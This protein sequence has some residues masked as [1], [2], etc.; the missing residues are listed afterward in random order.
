MYLCSNFLCFFKGVIK[1]VF[2]GKLVTRCKFGKI[3][4]G[5]FYLSKFTIKEHNQKVMGFLWK[6]IKFIYPFRSML[7]HKFIG[8]LFINMVVNCFHV[9]IIQQHIRIVKGVLYG[10]V[11]TIVSGGRMEVTGMMRTF[12][13]IFQAIY[14]Q[15]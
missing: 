1:V 14:L 15:T 7:L 5:F 4:F 3:L 8:S 2:E 9:F 6:V 10:C 11:S 13:K 12:L